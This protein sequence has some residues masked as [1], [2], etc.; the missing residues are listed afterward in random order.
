MANEISRK[1]HNKPHVKV[2]IA[3]MKR[4]ATVLGESIL[5]STAIKKKAMVRQTHKI[6][7]VHKLTAFLIHCMRLEMVL[8]SCNELWE[9][10]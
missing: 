6:E 4:I 9:R 7:R 5:N 8:I 2:S 1:K 3:V 10:S